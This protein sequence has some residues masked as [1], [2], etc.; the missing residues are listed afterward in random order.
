MSA[1]IREII[2]SKPPSKRTKTDKTSEADMAQ[3]ET[4]FIGYLKESLQFKL[5]EFVTKRNYITTNVNLDDLEDIAEWVESVDDSEESMKRKKGLNNIYHESMRETFDYIRRLS[6]SSSLVLEQESSGRK[7]SSYFSMFEE[8]LVWLKEL[9]K[10]YHLINDM[11]DKYMKECV[12][13]SLCVKEKNVDMIGCEDMYWHHFGCRQALSYM[14]LVLQA[15]AIGEQKYPDLEDIK[16]RFDVDVASQLCQN[17]RIEPPEGSSKVSRFNESRQVVQSLGGGYIREARC[18][19]SSFNIPFH[20]MDVDGDL[21]A[22]ASC[23]GY[24]YRE[25]EFRVIKM[26]QTSQNNDVETSFLNEDYPLK[27][28][29]YEPGFSV[30][31]SQLHSSVACMADERIKI[32]DMKKENMPCTATLQAKNCKGLLFFEDKII[33]SPRKGSHFFQWNMKDL[34][35]HVPM[36]LKAAQEEELPSSEWLNLVDSSMND[37]VMEYPHKIDVNIGQSPHLSSSIQGLSSDFCIDVISKNYASL[38]NSIFIASAKDPTIYVVDLNQSKVFRGLPGNVNIKG[39]TQISSCSQMPHLVMST[40]QDNQAKIW[41]LRCQSDLP[42]LTLCH[43]DNHDNH[44]GNAHACFAEDMLAFTAGE[45]QC[46]RAWDLRAPACLYKLSTG[47]TEAKSLRYSF[48]TKSLFASVHGHGCKQ[49]FP[50]KFFMHEWNAYT[51]LGVMFMQ[52]RSTCSNVLVYDFKETLD[53]NEILPVD[54]PKQDHD[55]YS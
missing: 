20:T 30:A 18:I 7:T 34:K 43:N 51:D 36:S 33:C 54:L 37:D 2:M 55:Y 35:E 13:G 47:N 39:N 3:E 14:K 6:T 41:D 23:T 1:P 29:F 15:R 5:K 24:K 49:F 11:T 53:V 19:V 48:Q 44:F 45:D 22:L 40:R 46:I 32:F 38:N 28:G 10:Q 21:M 25:P 42:T 50:P 16:Q 4:Y 12:D 9:I 27:T 17:N 26:K 52:H 31:C 8:V